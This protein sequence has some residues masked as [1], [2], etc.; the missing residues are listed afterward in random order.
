MDLSDEDIEDIFDIEHTDNIYDT[1]IQ[2]KDY[3]YN[4]YSYIFENIEFKIF[5]SFLKQ[6]IDLENSIDFLRDKNNPLDKEDETNIEQD[7]YAHNF[8]LTYRKKKEK[9]KDKEDLVFNH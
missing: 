2:I 3:E 9:A 8:Q 1:Y 5:Y 4:I 6:F 7:Y